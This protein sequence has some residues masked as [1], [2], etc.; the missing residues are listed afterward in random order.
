M[1]RLIS[2]RTDSY[3]A[4]LASSSSGN[5]VLSVSGKTRLLVDA[6][7]SL[8]RLTAAFSTCALSPGDLTAILITHEHSDHISGLSTLAT[9]FDLPV[10]ASQG[11]A[12]ALAGK[13]PALADNL[14][15][16]EAG[17]SFDIDGVGVETFS[18]P[19]DNLDSVCYLL[20][21]SGLRTAVVTDL[22]HVSADLAAQLT[23]AD[24][25]LL[26][27]NYDE[28]MLRSG[29]YADF[30][31]E[32]IA[33]QR[34]HLSNKDAGEAAVL[35]VKNG[36]RHIMLGHLSRDNNTPE[37]ALSATLGAMKS[38]GIRVGQDVDLSVAP[39]L[40]IC[41]I[42]D[43]CGDMYPLAAPETTGQTILSLAGE[44]I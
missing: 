37:L 31:K 9:R 43:F 38:A 11:T 30:L 34:G 33:G 1:N 36:V 42:P 2:H 8:R 5:A 24:A 13:C 26:E 41:R 28:N 17:K 19:H 7:L 29:R 25:V 32:R 40:G 14:R 12:R 10:Y 20:H 21:L 18:T 23:R 15:V 3:M 6:G 39:P 35:L 22:G 44:T 27:S 16:F 4:A